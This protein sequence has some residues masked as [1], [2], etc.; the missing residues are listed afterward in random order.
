MIYSAV[1]FHLFVLVNNS[2]SH[3]EII[4]GTVLGASEYVADALKESLEKNQHS[5]TIHLTPNLDDIS[6]DA[7]WILCSSTHGAGELP[8]N[9]QPFAKQLAD[10]DLSSVNYLIV[11]LGDSSYDTFCNAAMILESTLNQ[12]HAKSLEKALHVDVLHHPI[13]EDAAV[14][15]LED[16]LDRQ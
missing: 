4:V 9:I 15:W 6:Q 13:P 12:A 14:E 2:M 7:I 16:W 1:S 3:F 5:A 8:D 10:Q 11:G